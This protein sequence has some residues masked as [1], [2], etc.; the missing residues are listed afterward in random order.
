[1]ANTLG[2][3]PALNY[4]SASAYGASYGANF[5]TPTSLISPQGFDVLG[6]PRVFSSQEE[7]A[8]NNIRGFV[9]GMFN[10]SYSDGSA[11]VV[12]T[13]TDR[14]QLQQFI[15]D[16]YT[17]AQSSAFLNSWNAGSAMN[18]DMYNIL[19]A[20]EIIRTFTPELLVVNMQDV[21]VCHFQYTQ[22]ANNLRKADFAV[23]QLWKTIQSTPGMADDT[24]LIIAPEHGRNFYPNTSVDAYGRRALDHTA[25]TDPN[26]TGDPNMQMA[27]EIFCLVVGPPNVVVPLWEKAQKLFRLSRTYSDSIRTC[28]ERMELNPGLHASFKPPLYDQTTENN[29]A[30]DYGYAGCYGLVL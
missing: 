25:P 5:I 24:V 17:K 15:T 14:I 27:R 3:Y 1:V 21:D 16:L 18:N 30:D 12:N 7:A 10:H 2:P 23:A 6:N 8:V 13:D 29:P 26:F 9:N 20:E 11:G 19:F 22:Y 28:P 4:S